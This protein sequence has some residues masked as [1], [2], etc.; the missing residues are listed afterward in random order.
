MACTHG[1]I[2][3]I[4]LLVSI[5]QRNTIKAETKKN[6]I[7]LLADDLDVSLN[8]MTVMQKTNRLFQKEGVSFTNAFSTSPLC[9]PS[10][11]SILT[12]KY[13]HN[14]H[15][16]TNSYPVCAGP[17][18]INGPEKQSIGI[19]MQQ[20]GYK[21][22]YFGKYLNHYRGTRVPPGWSYWV[23]LLGN[24][25]YF[26][27]TLND[28]GR[29]INYGNNKK[30]YFTDVMTRRA[31][32]YFKT[33]KSS[34]PNEPVFMIVS[35]SAPHGPDDAAPQYRES[36][37]EKKAPRLPN[38]NYT[39]LDKHWLLRNTPPLNNVTERFTDVL[40][41]KRLQTL[42]S[43][44]DTVEKLY[45][46]LKRANQLN[47]TYFVFS[48]DHGYHLGQ[49]NQVK[50]KNEPYEAD[51]RIPLYI[52]GPGLPA[53][54]KTNRAATIIDLAPTF[55]DIAKAEPP[56]YMDG[57]S[58]MDTFVQNNPN[59]SKFKETVLVERNKM[60][61]KSPRPCKKW[62]QRLKLKLL[63]NPK[64]TVQKRTK[65]KRTAWSRKIPS[66]CVSEIRRRVNKSLWNRK[67]LH[68][69]EMT[70]KKWHTPP[71]WDGPDFVSC[72]NAKNSSFSCLRTISE[73]DDYLY[74]EFVTGF[75]EYFDIRRDPY[76]LRNRAHKLSAEKKYNL[77]TFLKHMRN[78][79]G[80]ES[81]NQHPT[82][83]LNRVS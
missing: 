17:A 73:S 56:K 83:I 61:K 9:C 7:F 40:Y 18:W 4:T 6:I 72:N 68:C 77:K 46:M 76:Q 54:M 8:S 20:A 23:G 70:R 65:T 3:F 48:S 74:C 12:G 13:E 66:T 15:V 64:H 47:N 60:K 43:V 62:I 14:H 11:S 51:I 35:M 38:Y 44:D 32:K 59:L 52:R 31:M 5:L 27:Y 50:G 71:Y 69:F 55:L 41:R 10:R 28:N 81:C 22:A 24:S 58:L 30:S 19:L 78:C 80:T 29:L 1:K 79:K 45:N 42:L 2:L 37:A 49:F 26:N 39:S 34:K 63:N 57:I 33:Q 53:G 16:N 82:Q 67:G 21:T 36:F 25:K 75:I